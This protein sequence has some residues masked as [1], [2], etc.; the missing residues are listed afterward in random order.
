MKPPANS[1]S[2][3][4][5]NATNCALPQLTSTTT[6]TS[7][8]YNKSWT[9][10]ELK[11][12]PSRHHQQLQHSNLH[13]PSLQSP[14]YQSSTPR[15]PHDPTGNNNINNIAPNNDDDDDDDDIDKSSNIDDNFLSHPGG[16]FSN[17]ASSRSFYLSNPN[18]N[19]NNNATHISS[20]KAP[21][22][23]I[24]PY[25]NIHNLYSNENSNNNNILKSSFPPFYAPDET[26]LLSFNKGFPLSEDFCRSI[27]SNHQN[28][29][30]LIPPPPLHTHN[31]Y[32]GYDSSSH[33][34]SSLTSP[35]TPYMFPTEPFQNSNPST[36]ALPSVLFS[37][38]TL[39][40]SINF[41]TST[42]TSSASIASDV[43]ATRHPDS[44]IGDC[45]SPLNSHQ[46]SINSIHNNNSNN[47][48]GVKKLKENYQPADNRSGVVHAG[49]ASHHPTTNQA[50]QTC[51]TPSENNK[52]ASTNHSN[53][54][55]HQSNNS[56]HNII[57][58]GDL[59][60]VNLPLC[61]ENNNNKSNNNSHS[62][63]ITMEGKE[64]MKTTT[65][66]TTNSS[67]NEEFMMDSMQ[68]TRQLADIF[69]TG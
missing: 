53:S 55:N 4:F 2:S 3:Y 41:F 52:I 23:P 12:S 58:N 17:W 69:S 24:N 29:S 39:N 47:S 57:S 61:R 32:H 31:F 25:Y 54:N 59:N 63:N 48:Y 68:P 33:N 64:N 20:N 38:S 65:N 13:H 27:Q 6:T 56:N 5:S 10:H 21:T 51:L 9:N 16:N 1:T 62:N 11:L 45:S 30:Q 36:L 14:L 42:L 49:A 60:N 34:H 15:P 46:Q 28:H 43:D 35:N 7:T 26:S 66:T 22:T 67:S 37:P 19:G 18:S 50:N 44:G 40:S 8:L